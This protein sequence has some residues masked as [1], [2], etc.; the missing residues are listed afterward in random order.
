M[1]QANRIKIVL[2]SFV[3]AIIFGV[4]LVTHSPKTLAQGA[5]TP[6]PTG[7]ASLAGTQ[8]TLTLGAYSTPRD[9]FAELIPL[10]TSEWLKQTGQKVTFKES[11]TGSGAQSR[12][13]VN[14]FEADI[15]VL[16]L[17]ADITRIVKAKLITHDW[18]KTPYNG[19]FATSLAIFVVRPG[20]PK[21]ITD[22]ADLAKPG[23]EVLTPNPATSGG[24]QWNILAGYGAA[25]RGNVTGY[26][27]GDDAGLKYVG[28]LFKNVTALHKDA[29]SS[30]LN[31]E[32]GI[33]DAAITYETDAIFNRTPQTQANGAAT[34]SATVAATVAATSAATGSAAAQYD[35]VYP[36]S[37][38]SIELPAALV[39][40][41]VDKHGVRPAAEAFIQF[42][43]SPEAQ[44]ILAK[45]GFRPVDP[46]VQKQDQ[47][48]KEFPTVKDV[49]TIQ[50]FGGW[51]KVAT[52]FFGDNGTITQLLSQVKG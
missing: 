7:S 16:S 41:Y 13:I 34:G 38:I 19:L 18:K 5:A 45:H 26:D 40:V 33:G 29:Q 32:H 46:T 23:I 25:K 1:S 47:V 6:A 39:D 37:T 4:L 11:Y 24:A 43:T 51:D 20:N 12:A 49:F 28:D 30:F 8:V 10:F 35:L 15:A 42:L 48:V 27:K 36:T 2:S 3:V 52:D 21:H 14:G 31:F 50:E 44:A 17:E 22:W 9:A